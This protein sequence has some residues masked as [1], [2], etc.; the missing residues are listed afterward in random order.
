MTIAQHELSDPRGP[1]DAALEA[2]QIGE[3]RALARAYW[4]G[5]PS[6]S[7]ARFLLS[8]IERL[9][10]ARLVDHRIAVLR[11]FTVEPIIPLLQ[12]EAA[13]WGCRLV[14]WIGDF[15]AYG[16]EVLDPSSGLYA[17]RPDSVILALQ[18]RDVAPQLWSDFGAL[19]DE[20]A[21]R[22]VAD[23]AAR[24]SDLVAQL[25]RQT[26]ASI[27]V[28]GLAPPPQPGEGLLGQR[29][30]MSQSEAISAVNRAMRERFADLN[31]VHLLDIDELQARHG[32]TRFH[33]EKKWV[34][35]KLPFTAEGLSWMAQE[36]WRWVAVSATP[37]AKVLALDL[38]NTLWGGVVGE[39]GLAGLK[40]GDE[41][42]GAYFKD[43]QRTVLDMARRGVLI[44]VVSKNNLDDAMKVF[45]EHPDM[46]LKREHLAALRVNWEPKAQNIVELSRELNLGLESF[47]FLDD[48]PVERAAVQR[49]LPDVIVPD[50]GSD[51]STYAGAL[52]R[53][54]QLERLSVSFEDLARTQMYAQERERQG[55]EARAESMEDFLASLDVRVETELIS[56]LSLA[57][58]SQLT[59]K[60]NQ[61][62]TTTRRYNEAQLAERLA[63]PAWSGFV[64]RA[65]D[66]F[67]DNGIVGVAL[68]H[69]DGVVS[70]IDTFLMSCRV[71]GRGIET[72]FLAYL[73]V[74][75]RRRGYER[76]Q[77]WFLPTPKNPPARDIYRRAGFQLME[78]GVEGD[79]WGLDLASD[80]ITVPPW[81]CDVSSD[82]PAKTGTL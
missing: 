25:R 60:T 65:R 77:G 31:S 36:W 12:A 41:H 61:L 40:L 59:I 8:R 10:G 56:A 16:Q 55:I 22:I 29:R 57:R 64:L 54:A 23:V 74:D 51:P 70:W 63:D 19:S 39:D 75:A 50:I 53:L 18:T 66:R 4:L 81:I 45:D 42:P 32:R 43:L 78:N 17:H 27:F 37:Q 38:D 79:L 46:L 68:I 82:A 73:A 49:A 52:R 9:W 47:V 5:A 34:T 80:S 7:N 14:P 11:S 72:A 21:G 76:L 33:S 3:A 67:G 71:I 24:L 44:T 2:N 26:S 58:A 69:G 20:T 30:R 13:L 62:N 1:I 15:N 35:T 6:N 48:N 28:H